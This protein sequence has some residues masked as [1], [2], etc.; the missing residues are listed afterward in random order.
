MLVFGAANG[1]AVEVDVD[2][3]VEREEELVVGVKAKGEVAVLLFVINDEVD[4]A[5]FAMIGELAFVVF[6][7]NC[8]VESLNV[9]NA[10][11]VVVEAKLKIDTGFAANGKG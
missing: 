7:T 2:V 6:P 4:D 11:V 9:P 10:F 3:V 1:E 5:V 8:V